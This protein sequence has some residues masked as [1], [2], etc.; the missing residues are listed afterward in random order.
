MSYEST[1]D[2]LPGLRLALGIADTA[3]SDSISAGHLEMLIKEAESQPVNLSLEQ[4]VALV[5]EAGGFKLPQTY[6][7]EFH[8]GQRVK[9]VT[10]EYQISGT[11]RSVLTKEDGSIRLVVEH[12]AE[13]GGSFLHIYSEANLEAL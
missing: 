5:R 6:H 12:K 1:R 9:K 8:I 2:C 7:P 11:V 3:A 13:G 4:A 10:G